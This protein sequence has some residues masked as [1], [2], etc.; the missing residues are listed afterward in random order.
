MGDHG[1]KEQDIN[2]NYWAPKYRSARRINGVG[3][4]TTSSDGKIN[5]K[6][7]TKAASESDKAQA[8]ENAKKDLEEIRTEQRENQFKL[9]DDWVIQYSNA[10]EKVQNK[11]DK[12]SNKQSMFYVNSEEWR[13]E[14]Q[15]QISLIEQQRKLREKEIKK[16]NELMKQK[17][18]TSQDY[19]KQ[20]A[21]IET[22]L[23][24]DEAETY[25]KRE[26]VIDS[27]IGSYND[28]LDEQDNML[29]ISE[30]NL[31]V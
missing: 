30:A 6:T 17:K 23:L 21:E 29:A 3:E 8:K 4:S 14:E 7:S 10:I 1:L 27:F 19:N 22:Q 18:I 24:A 31:K 25:S 2:N 11:I 12:S 26:S 9:I 16:I 20:I 13:K 5:T 15:S 28:K